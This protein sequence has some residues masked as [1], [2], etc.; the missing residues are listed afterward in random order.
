MARKPRPVDPTEGPLQ[1]FA[2]DLRAVREQAGNPTYRAL[3][4][5]AGFSASTLSDAAGGVRQP[6]LEVTLAYVGACGGD[7][8]L[9]ERRWE[10]L[11]RELAVRPA[12]VEAADT[13]AADATQTMAEEPEA[14]GEAAPN[15]AEQP[16][17]APL[18][19]ATE[20]E[21]AQP[22]EP[23]AT[24]AATL[25]GAGTRR[26]A[27]ARPGGRCSPWGPWPP[28]AHCSPSGCPGST[29][30][31]HSP[32]RPVRPSPTRLAC[33]RR[34]LPPASL[35]PPRRRCASPRRRRA[36][37][38]TSAPVPASTPPSCGPSRPTAPSS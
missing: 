14:V 16:A 17:P 22:A 27:N 3:A 4:T 2:H 30:R 34:A 25:P 29:S 15:A 1:A 10:E 31:T 9:W 26:T 12:G 32:S 21:A 19:E 13:A 33:R 20:A 7:V 8:E 28:S 35:R 38:P 18:A 36:P 11:S 37:A 6:S 23:V 5:L 24:A